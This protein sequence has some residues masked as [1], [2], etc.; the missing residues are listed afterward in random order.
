MK[1]LKVYEENGEFVLERVNQFGTSFKRSFITEEGLKEGLDSYRPVIHEYEIEASE[2][3]WALVINHLSQ[4]DM[5]ARLVGI[6]EPAKAD[7][8]VS[9]YYPDLTEA[10]YVEVDHN[11]TNPTDGKGQAD[12]V[13]LIT[14][15]IYSDNSKDIYHCINISPDAARRFA[16]AILKVCDE[17]DAE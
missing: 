3:V 10:H 14:G 15:S 6:T 12:A 17:I 1:K 11:Y 8:I 16:E 7:Y 5:K 2:D 9:E 13:S 4:V